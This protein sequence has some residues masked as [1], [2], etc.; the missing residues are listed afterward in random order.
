MKNKFKILA[1]LTAIQFTHIMD[2]M[3]LMPLGPLLIKLFDITPKQFGLLVSIY[4]LAAGI[5][6]FVA[7]FIVDRFDR[8][9][10]VTFI[11]ALFII[12]TACCAIAPTYEFLLLARLFSGCFGGIL[13]SIILAIVADIVPLNERAQAMGIIMTGFA[14]AS[15]FGVPFGLLLATHFSWHF[16]FIF[17]V[18]VS[19]IVLGVL[20]LILPSI[21]THISKENSIKHSLKTLFHFF[22]NRSTLSALSLTFVMVLGQFALIPF[23]SPYMVFNVGF[24]EK[25][26]AWIYLCGGTASFIVSPLIG[27]IADK[28]GHKTV[29]IASAGL[30]IVPIFLI[31]TLGK[32]SI[33]IAL[34]VTTS[35]FIVVTGRIVPVMTI[36]SSAASPKNRGAF[37]SLNTCIQHI[38][39]GL[40]SMISARIIFQQSNGELLHYPI[41]GFM[42]IA[43]SI[44]AILIV[45]NI[46]EIERTTKII[47]S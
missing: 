31:T 36:V 39:A 22:K 40:G 44:L 35:F 42:A 11:M 29:F 15:V 20:Q 32:V 14:L 17:L 1:V 27:R 9:K 4:T 23:I 12:A 28:M 30:S 18:M 46:K 7:S 37:M 8:K 43:T 2:F 33:P 47:E 19:I 21:A 13:T 34:L 25:Q 38:A 41:A 24:S 6:G 3:I 26:L 45:K 5:S 10:T 16:P